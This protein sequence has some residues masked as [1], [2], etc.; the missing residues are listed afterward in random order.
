MTNSRHNQHMAASNCQTSKTALQSLQK[1][2]CWQH[3]L[4]RQLLALLHCWQHN[5]CWC[6]Q[7]DPSQHPAST[8]CACFYY[9]QEHTVPASVTQTLSKHTIFY[10]PMT[11][12]FSGFVALA[13]PQAVETSRLNTKQKRP[14][15]TIITSAHMPHAGQQLL[16]VVQQDG[17]CYTNH[18]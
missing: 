16:P 10:T 7:P 18:G 13:N 12:R 8:A 5:D 6:G 2:L 11:G 3:S 17:S 1:A 14:L 9:A 4:S 15:S